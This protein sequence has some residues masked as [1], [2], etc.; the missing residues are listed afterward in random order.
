MRAIEASESR[1]WQTPCRGDGATK[2][3]ECLSTFHFR[4]MEWSRVSSTTSTEITHPIGFHEWLEAVPWTTVV[5]HYRHPVLCD[6]QW[7][8][9]AAT[10]ITL[11]QSPSTSNS[12]IKA[13]SASQRRQATPTASKSNTAQPSP[14]KSAGRNEFNSRLDYG[15][16]LQPSVS[17]MAK[18]P[19]NV[20]GSKHSAHPP[21]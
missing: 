2:A 9:D 20:P 13:K 18:S 15:F 1:S 19:A 10:R 16:S 8:Q 17:S 7:T 11:N 3:V 4:Q 5:V 21:C 6:Y 14:A 12:P